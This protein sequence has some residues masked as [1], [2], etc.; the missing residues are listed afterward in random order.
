MLARMTGDVSS[1]FLPTPYFS[2]NIPYHFL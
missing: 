2:F 1:Y